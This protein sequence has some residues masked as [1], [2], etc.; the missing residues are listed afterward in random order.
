MALYRANMFVHMQVAG[1]RISTKLWIRWIF[2]KLILA[3]SFLCISLN[4][5]GDADVNC[6]NIILIPLKFLKN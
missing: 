5:L 6:F 3:I 4:I 2:L 1:I